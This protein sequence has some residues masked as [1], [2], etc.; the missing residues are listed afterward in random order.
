M[1]SAIHQRL[2]SLTSE[3]ASSRFSSTVRRISAS[4]SSTMPPRMPALTSSAMRSAMT[5]S[6]PAPPPAAQPLAPAGQRAGRRVVADQ[7]AGPDGELAGEEPGIVGA[8]EPFGEEARRA[9]RADARLE[10]GRLEEVGVEEA[11]DVSGGAGLVPGQERGVRD[12]DAERVPEERGDGEP[13]GEAADHPGLG[14]RPHQPHPGRRVGDKV[15]CQEDRGQRGQD[16]GRQASGS[17]QGLAG[18]GVGHAVRRRFGRC[19]SRSRSRWLLAVAVG[20]R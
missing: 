6:E 18:K 7:G 4:T 9:E 13:V 12:R 16:R 11:P 17:G 19:G 8:R 20:P 10:L 14:H 3:T 1:L 5:A 2:R 15:R